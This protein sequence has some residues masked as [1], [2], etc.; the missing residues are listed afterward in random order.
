MVINS[1]NA[2]K[3][4]LMKS[5]RIPAI[6]LLL[7]ALISTISCSANEEEEQENT[8]LANTEENLTE[9]INA[10][11]ELQV[12]REV[13]LSFEINGKLSEIFFKEG[14]EVKKGTILAELKTESL[15]LAL[16]EAR[17]ANNSVQVAYHRAQV[18]VNQ[19]EVAFNN[20]A[21]GVAQAEITLKTAE[22]ELEQ[23][24][25]EFNL[26]DINAARA[27]V[28]TAERDWE[29]ALWTLGKYDEGT[30]GWDEYQKSVFQAEARLNAARDTLDAILFGFDTKEIEIRKLSVDAA[31]QSLENALASQ[32]SAQ[33]SLELAIQSMELTEQSMLLAGESVEIAEKQL[34]KAFLVAPFDGIIAN[35]NYEQ[36]KFVTTA[37]TIVHLIDM[38][39]LEVNV[40]VDEIDIPKVMVGQRA[41]I[42]VDS[43]P[44]I[45]LNGIVRYIS[46]VPAQGTG[47]NM[48]NVKITL[49]DPQGHNLRVGMSA[50]ADI[51]IS[52]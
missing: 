35:T 33:R 7:I 11:G 10:I 16:N 8:Q 2:R 43:L 22:Y 17:S 29:A 19:N 4:K 45:L 31:E 27:A 14:D 9:T 44:D 20:A 42:Q 3:F 46:L 51:I 41:I 52:E 40:E 5:L 48:Y 25:N 34:Q 47:I 1:S 30:P 38:E 13:K 21:T 23:T 28:V 37:M 39:S 32:E 50:T 6:L 36:G 15:V 12:S 49:D 26:T 24:Q 18:T